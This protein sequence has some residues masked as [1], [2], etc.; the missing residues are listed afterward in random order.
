[1][2][3]ARELRRL[4]AILAAD[5]VGYSRL[6]GRDE[7]GTLARLK[8]HRS[9]RLE[10]ALAR[11]G[12]RL[13]K[14]T[15]DGALVEF[16]SAADALNAAIEFQQAMA[17]ANFD[18][19]QHCRI[20]FRIGVHV[21]DVIVD[22]DD[23]YG[24]G[25]NVAARLEGEAPPGGIVI[26]GNARD[27]VANR[28]D[29]SFRDVGDLSLKNIERPVRAFQVVLERGDET[30]GVVRTQTDS[31]VLPVMPSEGPSIAVRPFAVLAEDKSLAFLA[32]GL[33][34]DVI[35]L[36]ARIPGFFVISRASSFAFRN[37]ETQVSVIAR[38]LGV[39]YVL[40]GSLRVVGEQVRVS[41][42]LVEAATGRML[43]SGKFDAGRSET[44]DLQ[45]DIA[46]GIIVELEP[47]L[48]RAEIAVIR[49]QRPENVDAWGCYRQAMGALGGG[50]WS[51]H[52]AAEA[53]GF[54]RR[55]LE[56]DGNFALARAQLA[57][58][59]ALAQTTGLVEPSAGQKALALAEAEAAVAA[60]AGSS[61][62]LGY[63]GC[64]IADLGQRERGVEILKQAVDLDPSNAQ[65]HVALGAAVAL[66]RDLDGGIVRMRH[67]IR[68]SPRDHRLAFWGWAL[69]SFLLLAKRPVEAIEEARLAARRD[70]RLHLPLV[71]EALALVATGQTDRAAST[72]NAAKRLRPKLTLQEIERSHGRR[73]A[74]VLAFVWEAPQTSWQPGPPG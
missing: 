47:A 9:E 10:P 59:S 17:V 53:D 41:T 42:N 55:A 25:V 62:V 32:D 15:G 4:A 35:A 58:V 38:Q 20:I 46:R 70:P 2:L 45:D 69:G 56:L 36:L 40:E 44:L 6:M 64:A 37:P 7:S 48:T 13:V 1:M 23:L 12:G 33:A 49:R 24:D 54:L 26:S 60:D 68:L 29:A 51:E 34:E 5:V 22:G 67:G 19:P 39:R 57:L 63:A 14:L 30:A 43:W 16:A 11:H 66:A 72:L 50:G 28:R 3:L 71:L 27:A 8:A 21:G 18:D 52:A 31:A 65:A 74:Q 61:E 73:A